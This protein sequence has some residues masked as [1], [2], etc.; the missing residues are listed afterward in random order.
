MKYLNT[1]VFACF[2]L[3]AGAAPAASGSAEPS[4]SPDTLERVITLPVDG[5]ILI[6]PQGQVAEFQSNTPLPPELREKVDRNVLAWRFRMTS[7]NLLLGGRAQIRVVL[8]AT[9]V[10]DGYAVKIDNVLFPGVPDPRAAAF[11]TTPLISG[12][13][14]KPPLFP[15]PLQRAG[16]SGTV[17]LAVLVGADGHAEKVI[18]V[19]SMVFDVRGSDRVLAEA[20]RQFEKSAVYAARRWTYNVAPAR[21]ALPADARTVMVPVAFTMEETDSTAPGTWRTVVRAPK[22]SIE[23]LPDVPGS[24]HVGVS[25]INAGEMIPAVSLVQLTSDVIGKALL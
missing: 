12:K 24:Q 9:K 7:D 22:R 19:Q 25:D 11:E 16:V 1:A 5:S 23:W 14:L 15:M 18:P 4:A 21:G 13:S 17:L 8:A 2:V 6:T 20:I 3:L 10:G